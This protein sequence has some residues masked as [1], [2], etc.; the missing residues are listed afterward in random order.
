MQLTPAH[1]IRVLDGDTFALYHVGVPAEER[2]RVLGVD[3]AELRDTLGAAAKAFTMGWIAA[4]PFKMET[5]KRDGFGRLLAVVTRGADT[6]ALELIRARL[7][8]PR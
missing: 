5:C 2:V 4:G 1:V 6:L 7:G 8:V 3:A